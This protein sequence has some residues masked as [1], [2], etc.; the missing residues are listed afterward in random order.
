M[1]CTIELLLAM[2]GDDGESAKGN[3]ACTAF[4]PVIADAVKGCVSLLRLC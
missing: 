2:V 3:T 1:H 4:S